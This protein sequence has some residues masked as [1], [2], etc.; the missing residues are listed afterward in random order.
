[1]FGRYYCQIVFLKYLSKS[2][3]FTIFVSD[4]KV[5]L[6][7]VSRGEQFVRKIRLT[8]DNYKTNIECGLLKIKPTATLKMCTS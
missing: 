5:A 6:I 3:N 7:S 8:L 2:P 1:M 4:S